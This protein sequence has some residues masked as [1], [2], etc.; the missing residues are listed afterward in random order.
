MTASAPLTR[1]ST[2]RYPG[3]LT[4]RY[5]WTGSGGGDELFALSE[6]RGHLRDLGPLVSPHPERLCRAELRAEG[7]QGEW[8]V[9]LASVV[10]DEP[11]AATWD[12]PGLLAVAYGMRLYGLDARSGELRWSWAG[13]SPLIAVI[14]SPR[15]PHVLAQGEIETA[16][17]DAAGEVAWRRTHS[18]VVVAAELVGGRLVLTGYAGQRIAIDPLSGEEIG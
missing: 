8:T 18:E 2:V 16:A 6:A 3:G 12:T 9:R 5:R 13:G 7:P 15:L 17:L 4:V 10:Y 14:S 11:Q 1:R